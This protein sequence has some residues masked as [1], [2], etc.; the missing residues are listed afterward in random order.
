[1]TTLASAELAAAL[2]QL[3][4][5]LG[6][7]G[8]FVFLH[9]RYRKPHFLWWGLAWIGYALRLG[10]IVTFL[11]TNQYV[12]L[13][14]HQ[15]ATGW[16]ALALLWAALVFSRQLAWRRSYALTLALPLV[17]SYLA[18]IKRNDFLLA[19][20]P[21]V[22][23]LSATTAWTGLVFWQ[24]RRRTGSPA[25]GF[26]AW[27]LFLWGAHHLDYPLL[28]ARGAWSHWGYYLDSLFLL[29]V[30]AG[31][32]LLVI[33]E[34]RQGVLTLTAL[35]ADLS[36]R[37]RDDFVTALL[38]RPLAL[39]GV[40]GA[41]L[42]TGGSPPELIR[43][44]GDCSTWSAPA[45]VPA[46]VQSQA[47][48]ALASGQPIL[49]GQPRPAPGSPPFAAVLPLRAGGEALALVVVGDVA[50]PFAALD[51][52]VLIA[53]GA[54][55]GAAL[56]VI[57][58]TRRLED[59]GA[60]LELM[61]ARM[62]HVH[63]EQRRR[64]A[65][66]L[67]DETAQVFS[68]LK[69]QVGSLKET[70][71]EQLGPRFDRLIELVDA[72]TSSIRSVTED[73]RPAVLDDLGL[74]PALRALTAQFAH[75]SGLDVGFEAPSDGPTL[76][77]DAS[78]AAFRAVQEGLSNAARHSAATRV[79]VRIEPAALGLKILVDDDGVGLPAEQTA[80]LTSGSG[81]SGL[82]GL[83]ERITQVGGRVSL[84]AGPAGGLRLEVDLPASAAELG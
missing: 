43:A 17:W 65:R 11:V 14:W 77:P 24:H 10:A 45:V 64:L 21:A 69:L 83:R 81:R 8:L 72:G 62:V 26:L 16:T 31:I 36:Q 71:P 78:L 33:E 44:V 84:G 19:A 80:R 54:Q 50:A 56:E 25:A 27:T 55:I 75:W 22:L 20:I 66:E 9:R 46:T 82:F 57:G 40:R 63:E 67:H 42:L 34:L 48:A 29:A 76:E 70:A 35:S 3:A 12:W 28:R 74:V 52:R 32:L 5:T 13:F 68:A 15:V 2:F 18:V 1:M 7:A 61:A 38:R 73:L 49:S 39:R 47:T 4:L 53:V 79:N 6:L 23:F 41:A 30:G 51:D 58:L 59:R 60:D 37:D